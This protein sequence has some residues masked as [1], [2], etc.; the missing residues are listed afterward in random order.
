MYIYIYIYIYRY[1]WTLRVCP[2]QEARGPGETCLTCNRGLDEDT[3]DGTS[4]KV[5]KSIHYTR[6][7]KDNNQNSENRTNYET[8]DILDGTNLCV[9]I[10]LIHNYTTTNHKKTNHFH[11]SRPKDLEHKTITTQPTHNTRTQTTF[12]C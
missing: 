9:V 1:T 4:R 3:L 5:Q 6:P 7:T 10:E 12:I 2:L 8:K 11:I